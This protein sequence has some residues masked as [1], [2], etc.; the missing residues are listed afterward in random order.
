MR[1]KKVGPRVLNYVTIKYLVGLNKRLAKKEASFINFKETS[2]FM[3]LPKVSVEELFA[4]GVHL[5][6]STSRWHPKMAPYIHSKRSGRY[7]INL[8]ETQQALV[9][10]APAI[11]ETVASGRQILFVSTKR[12]AKEI[13]KETAQDLKMPFVTER[14]MGGM[15]TN[16]KTIQVQ[17]EKLKDLERR[18]VSGELTN[19]YNKL[20][21]QNIQKQI[22]S[23]NQVYGG[24]KDLRQ[25]PGLVFVADLINQAIAV[26]EA[27]KLKIPVAAIVDTNTDPSLVDYPIFGNDDAIRSIKTIVGFVSKV[28]AAGQVEAAKR[29]AAKPVEAE[30][31]PRQSDHP[32]SEAKRPET[33]SIDMVG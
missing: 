19:K 8:T 2:I 29:Q 3:Q 14:W 11:Y 25:A 10:L 27:R 32:Q 9:K 4:A 7:L 5:G 23:L 12:Q 13:I 24:I 22:D 33:M 17:V 21:V 16:Q 1:S 18:M 26:A 20:E 30:T 28:V 15:L 6:H 31:A